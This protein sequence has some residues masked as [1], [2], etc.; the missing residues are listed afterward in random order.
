VADNK[1]NIWRAGALPISEWQWCPG[2][3]D[4]AVMKAFEKAFEEGRL[5]PQ[6]TIFIGGIGCSGQARNYIGGHGFHGT[7]GGALSYATGIAVANPEL[8]VWVFAGD[9]DTFAIGIESFI[10]TCRRNPN[11][12]VVIADNE[13]YGLTKGQNSPTS[14]VFVPEVWSEEEPVSIQPLRLAIDVGATFVAQISSGDVRHCVEIYLAA[15]RHKGL[16]II[17][18]FSPCVTY[19]PEKKRV[20]AWY[21]ERVEKIE[22]RFPDHDPSKK[23]AAIELL[24]DFEERGKFPLG[25]I[26]RY[27][28]PMKPRE[29]APIFDK[30]LHLSD[31]KFEQLLGRFK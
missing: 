27:E 10:A 1:L 6:K 25:I 14:R 31:A 4:F 9:G 8:S 3:G 30:E 21:K 26:Y 17:N 12:K 24:L 29:R 13:V 7:H 15:M 22:E 28:R 18:D 19:H 5:D 2:C 20:H 11:V 16:A 23:S